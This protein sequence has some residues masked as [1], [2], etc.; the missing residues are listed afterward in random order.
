[1]LINLLLEYNKNNV[2]MT[3]NKKI[4]LLLVE[5]R[6]IVRDVL[7]LMLSKIEFVDVLDE[8]EDGLEAIKLVNKNNYDVIIMDINMPN[9]N[10]MDATEALKKNNHNLKILAHSFHQSAHYI[11]KIIHAGANGYLLKGAGLDEYREAIWTVFNNGIYLSDKIDNTIYEKVYRN[12]KY[13]TI[14]VK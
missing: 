4:K 9:L 12:L 8:A 14:D 3:L 7:K 13:P 6:T 11:N 1:M 5:D 10:G 2:I